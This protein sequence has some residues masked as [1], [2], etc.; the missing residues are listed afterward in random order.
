MASWLRD[1]EVSIRV[2][3]WQFYK[4]LSSSCMHLTS[5]QTVKQDARLKLGYTQAAVY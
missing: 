1:G 3:K 4:V 5:Q 2:S